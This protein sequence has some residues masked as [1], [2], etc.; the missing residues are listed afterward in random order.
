MARYKPTNYA[1]G[2]FISI[3]FEHQ[4]LPGTFEHALNYIV[5]NKLR[6]ER[7]DAVR[8]NDDGGAPAYN[9]RVM[10]KIV[11]FAYSRGIVSSREIEAACNQNVVMMALSA[12]TRPHFTT[13]AQFVRELD[14]AI[15]DL[16]VDVLLYCDELDL[17]GREMFAIDGCKFSSN[18]SKEW[19][20]TREDF[21][22]KKVKFRATIDRLV[23]KHRAMDEEGDSEAM[24]G[25][26]A[27]EEKA[28]KALEAKAA[29]IDAWLNENPEDRKGA[30]GG[31]LKSSMTDID[32]AKMTSGRGVIQGYNGVVVADAKHQIIVGA[33]AIGNANE[34]K[35]LGPMMDQVRETFRK[36]GDEDIYREVKVTADSGFHSEDSIKG[37]ADRGIDGYVVDKGFRKRDAA[38][39]TADRHRSFKALIGR[40][41]YKRKYFRAADFIHNPENGKLI[42]PAGKELY[43]KDRN[44][45]TH[46]GYFGIQYM[47]KK[48]DCGVCELRTQ[49][50]RNLDSPARTVHKLNRRELSPERMTFS[51]KMMEKMESAAGR[52]LYGL[53]MGIV[54]PVFANLRCMLGLDR[55]TLR[56]ARK[57]NTQWQL[58]TLVHNLGKIHRFA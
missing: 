56:G 28:I 52:Y 49:C 33:E 38:F 43:V 34:A 12:N 30:R 41:R 3:A 23:K 22:K 10:L 54:E 5:D 24:P 55:F 40:S 8:N 53:R 9:P 37:L 46:N 2:Q 35:A 11:L 57:V 39:K 16:F 7:L 25:M 29:K 50:L 44:F 36:L 58:F 31:A 20:G 18:A 48:T 45:K 26:R 1:Q 17:I 15:K 42:C 21:E 19:S 6:F 13:I 14:N 47:A 4:I 27:R 32:S 51:R